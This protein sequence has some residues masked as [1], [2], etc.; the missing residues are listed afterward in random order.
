MKFQNLSFPVLFI[1]I[2]GCTF[3]ETNKLSGENS[4][5]SGKIDSL[6]TLAE[7]PQNKIE[8][9]INPS[10][11]P[12][13]SKNLFNCFNQN[14]EKYSCDLT[15]DITLYNHYMD[16]NRNLKYIYSELWKVNDESIYT[17]PIP[18]EF[19][20]L[21]EFSDI[22]LDRSDTANLNYFIEISYQF[23][24]SQSYNSLKLLNPKYS[25]TYIVYSNNISHS[26]L[27]KN[28]FIYIKGFPLSEINQEFLNQ[29]KTND[30]EYALNQILIYIVVKEKKWEYEYKKL[31]I[32][33]VASKIL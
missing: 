2:T 31:Y 19:D 16:R 21:I 24:Y 28:M 9:L 11:I 15:V 22:Y 32:H 5:T 25:S 27:F 17:C 13:Y 30:C 3:T 23:I 26:D 20:A 29:N 7:I 10:I 8:I 18:N 6:Y 14:Y 33:P 4:M 12:T 1:L